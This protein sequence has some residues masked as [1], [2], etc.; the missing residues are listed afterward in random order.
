MLMKLL[1][2][3][4]GRVWLLLAAVAINGAAW[5]WVSYHT[6]QLE[7]ELSQTQAEAEVLRKGL[8]A[9]QA[10]ADSYRDD[11]AIAIAE[12]AHAERAVRE[13]QAELADSG[14]R[15]R[16]LQARIRQAPERDDGPVAP[17]LRDALEAL[18]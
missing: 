8:D 1:R 13:L 16:E 18:P 6:A 7:R 11:L 3:V 17:V 5:L 15:Y 14:A 2:L 10:R 4:P 9:W 12:Q